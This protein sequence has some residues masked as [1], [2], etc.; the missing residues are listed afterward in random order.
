MTPE[1]VLANVCTTYSVPLRTLLGRRRDAWLS[2]ARRDAT[3]RLYALGMPPKE[4][5][6]RL[7]RDRTT[8]LYF[9]HGRNRK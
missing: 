4:I 6:R 2:K 5:G 7:K 9:L 1:S 8:I 3:R